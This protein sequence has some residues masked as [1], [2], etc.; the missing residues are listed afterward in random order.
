MQV[1]GAFHSIE[2]SCVI[3]IINVQELNIFVFTANEPGNVQ[4]EIK[5]GKPVF[6]TDFDVIY[7]A[8]CNVIHF[9]TYGDADSA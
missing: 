9:P 3:S 2:K 5:Y 1:N 8:S 7:E 4:L 6:G